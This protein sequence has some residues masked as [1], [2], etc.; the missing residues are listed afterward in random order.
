MML[1]GRNRIFFTSALL[2]LGAWLDLEGV[3]FR[4]SGLDLA[5]A[6]ELRVELGTE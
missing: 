3:P 2:R 1:N 5:A 6:L 4:D